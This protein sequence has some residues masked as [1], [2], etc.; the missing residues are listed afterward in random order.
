MEGE[1]SCGEH[2]LKKTEGERK[3]PPHPPIARMGKAK[4]KEKKLLP[5]ELVLKG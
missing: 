1:G 2:R 3:H 4:S 5:S